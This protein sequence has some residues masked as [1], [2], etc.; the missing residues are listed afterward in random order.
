MA[1]Y[2]QTVAELIEY[3]KRKLGGE[4]HDI[5]I[6]T[7]QWDDIIEDSKHWLYDY[8]EFGTY[9]QWEIVE[10]N[11][12]SSMVLSDDVLGIKECY[13][14]NDIANIPNF[15]FPVD[16]LFYSVIRDGAATFS[17]SSYVVMR[18]YLNTFRDLFREP[19]IFNFNGESKRL[20]FPNSHYKSIGFLL[21]KEETTDKLVNN[22]F[23]KMLVEAHA[24]KQ[25]AINMG[26]KYNVANASIIGNGLT[27]NV[28][29]MYDRA[30][31]LFEKIE[32]GLDADEFGTLL[33]PKRLYN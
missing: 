18:Q 6:T 28:D 3:T 24:W 26:G 21:I 2:L 10:P 16:S 19:V 8:S 23:F 1:R 14:M 7:T 12:A 13:G 31:K 25:W 29:Q 17:I 5:E 15:A 20:E 27:L 4:I 11:G 30:E 32:E 9:E 33:M 22:K